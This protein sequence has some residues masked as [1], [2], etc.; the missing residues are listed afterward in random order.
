MSKAETSEISRPISQLKPP[1]EFDF[2]S[3]NVAHSWKRWRNEVELYMELA[4][5]GKNEETKVK[6]FLYIVGNQGREIYETLSFDQEPEERSL[7]CVIE[8]FSNY[9][10]PKKNETVE[11][12]KFFTRIQEVG[13]SLDKFITDIKILA[14]TCNFE[15]LKESLIRDRII[16]GMTDSKLRQDLLKIPELSLDKCIENCR[17]AELSKE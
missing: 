3:I 17:A 5:V 1:A 11:R 10:D 15:Q 6:L 7:K 8:A 2:D 12:Y 16:C 9:C 14:A 4:M 13:E